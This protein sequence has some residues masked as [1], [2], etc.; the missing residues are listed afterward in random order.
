MVLPE[1]LKKLLIDISIA[2]E[3]IKID[4]TEDGGICLMIRLPYFDTY[5]S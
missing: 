3:Y 1:E 4:V 2:A 5:I